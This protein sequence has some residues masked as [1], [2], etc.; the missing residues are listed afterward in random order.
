MN[1]IESYGPHYFRQYGMG[2]IKNTPD[3]FS[4]LVCTKSDERSFRSIFGVSWDVT[5]R[6]WSLLESYG[7]NKYK[8]PFHLLWALL[9]AKQYG[10]EQSHCMMVG[11]N[12]SLKTFRKWVWIIL[13]EMSSISSIKVR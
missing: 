3:S 7:A 6:L 4:E 10:N 1:K 11:G 2:M 9:F 12:V 5:A 13:E 8:R